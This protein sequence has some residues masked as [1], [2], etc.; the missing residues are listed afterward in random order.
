MLS[1]TQG[2]RDHRTARTLSNLAFLY[3][4][5]GQLPKAKQFYERAL[6][7]LEHSVGAQH[8]LT[9]Q[10]INDLGMLLHAMGNLEESLAYL[11]S[12]LEIRRQTQGEGHPAIAL[13]L[14]QVGLLFSQMGKPET[15]EKHFTQALA[16]MEKVKGG[17]LQPLTAQILSNLAALYWQKNA[18]DRAR[19]ILR[20]ALI[21]Y[22][23]TLG[24]EHTET[25]EVNRNLVRLEGVLAR[26]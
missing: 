12:E 10:C 6:K 23:L 9:M 16:I 8:P 26:T 14:N 11:T 21:T 5:E 15:A 18:L 17:I 7:I 4:A 24:S 1:S 22:Q 2:T 25:Q 20:R 3:A 19:I 13:C